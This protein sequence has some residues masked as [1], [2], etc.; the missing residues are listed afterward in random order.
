MKI[1]KLTENDVIKAIETPEDGMGFQK[2]RLSSNGTP[3]SGILINGQYFMSLDDAPLLEGTRGFS[4]INR[5]LS[6][7]MFLDPPESIDVA[8]FTG[9]GRVYVGSLLLESSATKG[10]RLSKSISGSRPPHVAVTKAGEVFFRLSAY[11]TDR[12]VLP[13]RSLAPQSY[14]T[15]DTDITVVPNG[16]AAVGRYAL[17]TRISAKEVFG[18]WPTANTPILY[19]TVTPNYGLAGGGVEVFFPM[20]TTPGTVRR[21]KTLPEK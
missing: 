20:G 3:T 1:F 16:L 18:I 13:D 2:A 8:N 6:E 11:K 9:V 7:C 10:A 19:G 17:P 21:I 12:R 15:T 4:D 14:S 5:N